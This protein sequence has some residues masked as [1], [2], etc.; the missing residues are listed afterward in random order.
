[1][2]KM[3]L[4]ESLVVS[5]MR[6]H[7][8]DQ[9]DEE[10]EQ[11]IKRGLQEKLDAI[12]RRKLYSQSLTAPTAAER[13]AARREYLDATGIMDEWKWSQGYEEKRHN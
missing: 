6:Y 13:E 10:T 4:D 8:L 5:I 2:G 9:R 7:L 3:Q 12:T 1:M 11:R